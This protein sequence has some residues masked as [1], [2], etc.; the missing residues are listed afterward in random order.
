MINTCNTVCTCI[1]FNVY[2]ERRHQAISP[3]LN[4]HAN[5]CVHCMY[6]Y[7]IM[8]YTYIATYVCDQIFYTYKSH[9]NVCM[10]VRIS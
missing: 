9:I 1:H 2:M 3:A 4:V 7:I 10:Y 8:Y 5:I 6:N